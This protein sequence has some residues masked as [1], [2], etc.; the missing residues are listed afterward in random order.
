MINKNDIINNN[1]YIHELMGINYNLNH[2]EIFNE[3]EQ[4]RI[5]KI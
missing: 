3:I 4:Q 1:K 2:P 5:S